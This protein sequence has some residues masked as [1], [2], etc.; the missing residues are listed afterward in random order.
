M[1]DALNMY[2]V[3]WR[4]KKVYMIQNQNVSKILAKIKWW[5][6]ELVYSSI[7]EQSK[8]QYVNIYTTISFLL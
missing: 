7:R 1:L 5:Q 6:I 4:A 3:L 8:V 2:K